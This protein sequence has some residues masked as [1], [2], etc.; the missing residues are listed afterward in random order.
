M[1]A[2]NTIFIVVLNFFGPASDTH[3]EA[4]NTIFIVHFR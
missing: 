1:E 3:E 2:K 4:R